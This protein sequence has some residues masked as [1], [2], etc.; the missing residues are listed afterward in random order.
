[1]SIHLPFLSFD[2][3]HNQQFVETDTTY[4][5]DNPTLG[6]QRR[7]AVDFTHDVMILQNIQKAVEGISQRER[8]NAV[9]FTHNQEIMKI[10]AEA[11]K[12]ASQLYTYIEL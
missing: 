9:D 5:Q 4:F 1:M 7:N 8:R 2:L 10:I 3:S 12:E 11:V 6:L